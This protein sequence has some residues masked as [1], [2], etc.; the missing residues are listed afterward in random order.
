MRPSSW[1]LI[2][3]SPDMGATRNRLSVSLAVS[4]DGVAHQIINR[5][6]TGW[7]RP[8]ALAIDHH[9]LGRHVG[10]GGIG[11]VGAVLRRN[12]LGPGWWREVGSRGGAGADGDTETSDADLSQL[13][14]GDLEQS[15]S[16]P[17]RGMPTH[18]LRV[19]VVRDKTW[20]AHRLPASATGSRNRCRNRVQS[21]G[22]EVTHYP[23]TTAPVFLKC[24]SVQ[25][26]F[27]F[28]CRQ[29]FLPS[30]NLRPSNLL[31]AKGHD[32]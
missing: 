11:Q 9:R 30:G 21:C 26:L 16:R 17:S 13:S 15:R 10:G 1:V 18:T 23:T 2:S 27:I 6:N 8:S 29:L 5:W 19:L 32:R 20:P 31:A 25:S 28:L 7:H 24:T 4:S 3:T 22:P 12:H 14:T